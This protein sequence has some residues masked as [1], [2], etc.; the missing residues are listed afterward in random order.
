VGEYLAID[1]GATSGRVTAGR[2]E[3]GRLSTREV[4]RFPNR[5]LGEGAALRWD[6][7]A[8]FDATLA[9]LE[10][11]C[12]RGRP[13]DGIAVSAWGVDFGLVDAEG[14]LL[15][16][17]AHYRSASPAARDRFLRDI[18]AEEL[19]LR[20]GV[21]PN[22][23]NT[24]FRLGDIARRLSPPEGTTALLM[25]DLWTF[26]LC[27]ARGAEHTI[28]GTTGLLDARTAD[29][30]RRLAERAGIDPRL[31]PAVSSPGGFAGRLEPEL[32]ARLGAGDDVPVYRAASHDTASAVAAIPGDGHVAFV[33]CG[34]WALAGIEHDRPVLAAEALRAGFTNEVGFGGRVRLLRNL[35]GLWLLEQALRRWRAADPSVTV[36]RA[37][38]AAEREGPVASFIDVADPELIAGD[39]VLGLIA[40]ACR[41]ADRPVPETPAQVTRCI[42]QSLALA[43]R[44]TIEHCERLTART[45]DVVHMV[46]GGSR[47]ALLCRLTADACR[48]QVLAG[49]AEAT[50]AGNLLVQAIA[51]GELGS[52]EE[53]RDVVRRSHEVLRYD[54]GDHDRGLWD[55]AA[56]L[57]AS[58]STIEGERVH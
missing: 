57:F 16:A 21:G 23:I 48:R 5:P 39:D 17:P 43:F 33:S 30:D 3:G 51:S 12:V 38:A 6:V 50:S 32:A 22:Q 37:V 29:W 26:R 41:R 56:A 24:L 27:G 10:A 2:L 14:R 52:L 55:S 36:E 25:P 34:T 8:L 9:G 46:G 58:D 42:L 44:A 35:T 31:L 45:V 18:A 1:L 15:E 4:H 11:G 47:N 13:P 40:Q 49:P 28:A 54:P 19:F 20:T 7:D 53:L